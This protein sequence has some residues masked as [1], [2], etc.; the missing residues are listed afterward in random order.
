MDEKKAKYIAAI[1]ELLILLCIAG[2][3]I[4]RHLSKYVLVE[5]N[6]DFIKNRNNPAVAASSGILGKNPLEILNGIIGQRIK[7]IFKQFL[8]FL[9]PIF[10]IIS[11]I[12]GVFQNSINKLR[13]LLRPIRD[14]F[15]AAAEKFYSA[16][17][18]YVIGAVYSLNKMRNSMRR[19]LSG[20][21]LVFHTVEHAKNSLQSLITSPP[22]RLAMKFLEPLEWIE[23]ASSKLFCFSPYAV[24]EKNDGSYQYIKDF[25]VGDELSDGSIIICKQIFQKKEPLYKC[26]KE[27]YYDLFVTGEHKVLENNKWICV[28]DS[29]IF[30]KTENESEYLYCLSTDTGIINIE[31]VMFKDYS[32]S[33]N[34]FL[35]Y[36]V[37]SLILS[38]L[39]NNVDLGCKYAAEVKELEHG[40]D[41]DTLVDT[42]DGLKR[43]S[44]ITIGTKLSGDNYVIGTVELLPSYF[45]FYIYDTI[46]MTSNMKVVENNIWKNIEKTY[47]GKKSID[48]PGKCIN[49]VTTN[50]KIPIFYT[51]EYIDYTEVHDNIINDR[52]DEIL[53]EA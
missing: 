26:T 49:L 52:I 19:S 39:N 12:F 13:N 3:L 27:L 5:V 33:K 37:N 20:F 28:K 50:G 18:K 29:T 47:M 10:S 21:N 41:G 34:K 35:N 42:I 15:K 1:I 7:G 14:F 53:E 9:T 23:D 44:D 51:K 40:F 16:I 31:G 22:I 25:E 24:L 45:E 6:K 11:K 38:K 48:K 8:K 2:Y 17:S 30:I 32:E 4:G 43:L 36:T 46:N